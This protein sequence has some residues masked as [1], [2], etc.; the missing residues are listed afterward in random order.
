MSWCG[1]KDK[2][3]EQA[4]A[5]EE[6]RQQDIRL[7]TSNIDREFA[8]FDDSFY[9]NR[10]KAYQDF[11]LP[12]LGQQ[13]NDQ[14]RNLAYKLAN[15]RILGSSAARFLKGKLDEATAQQRRGIVDTAQQQ[16]NQLRQ[17]VAQEKGTL[18]NQ[19]QLSADPAG[20]RASAL[21]TASSLSLPSTFQPVSNFLQGW[22]NTYLTDRV[23]QAYNQTNRNNA[24]VG[25]ATTPVT[26]R[27]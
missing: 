22:A 26:N 13:Y 17:Q 1:G 24:G 16:A 11:A 27:Y 4:R 21:A 10:A 25:F 12:Q 14:S 7:A 8:G 3:G 18:Y 6:Q 15:Q 19:A 9:A 5:A 23:A 20:A 2:V